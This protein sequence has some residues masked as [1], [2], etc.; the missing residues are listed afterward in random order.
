MKVNQYNKYFIGPRFYYMKDPSDDTFCYHYFIGMA[1]ENDIEKSFLEELD[2]TFKRNGVKYCCKGYD[3]YDF[4]EDPINNRHEQDDVFSYY[5]DKGNSLYSYIKDIMCLVYKYRP[6]IFRSTDH[7]SFLEQS[8]INFDVFKRLHKAEINGVI[9]AYINYL[10]ENVPHEETAIVTENQYVIDELL[11]VGYEG[12]LF[13]VEEGYDVFSAYCDFIHTLS[14]Y[15]LKLVAKGDSINPREKKLLNLMRAA[16][17]LAIH[18]KNS[19]FTKNYDKE[20]E[21]YFAPKPKK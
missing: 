10:G 2:K 11:E 16:Y 3:D 5:F 1:Y 12:S 18:R 8:N 9:F 21:K 17:A 4:Y 13:K 7:R 20:I 6:L 15:I 19:I 14:N